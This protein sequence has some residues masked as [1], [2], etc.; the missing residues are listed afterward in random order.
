MA[1]TVALESGRH[2]AFWR[3]NGRWRADRIAHLSR[4]AKAWARRGAREADAA[5]GYIAGNRLV[6]AVSR[7]LRSAVTAYDEDELDAKAEAGARLCAALLV[8]ASD[9]KDRPAPAGTPE[10]IRA[11]VARRRAEWLDSA[12]RYATSRGLVLPAG[13]SVTAD[14]LRARL[15]DAGWWRRRLRALYGRAAESAFRDLG[16]VHRHADPYITDDGL[17]RYFEQ[18]A[19]TA[20]FLGS[21]DVACEQTGELFPLADIA[22]K[23]LACESIRRG[24]LA[25]R[26]RGLEEHAR[27][28]GHSWAFFTLTAPSAFHPRLAA[29]GAPNPAYQ[30]STVREARD[31]LQRLWSRVRAKSKRLGLKFYG[32]RVAEPHHDGTP[33]WHLMMFGPARDLAAL[34]ECIQGYWYS[35]HREEL[36]SPA[37]YEARAQRKLPDPAKGESATGYLL[38]YIA[39]GIDGHRLDGDDPE[40]T[41]LTGSE[42]SARVVAWARLHGIRQFQ[43]IGGPRV[44]IYRELRRLREPVA[45][46]ALEAAR[47]AADSGDFAAYWRASAGLALDK[48]APRTVDRHGRRVLRLTRWGEVPADR[49]IGVSVVGALGRIVRAVTRPFS[50][51]RIRRAERVP[52]LGPVAIT[53]RAERSEAPAAGQESAGLGVRARQLWDRMRPKE[54]LTGAAADRFDR[55]WAAQLTRVGYQ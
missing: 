8:G 26:S 15:S 45:E 27:A 11:E 40:E 29:S 14:G 52:D 17:R 41:D 12:C 10:E 51:V 54:P 30:R 36:T 32:I 38:K 31:H 47:L 33:H 44:G 50:W 7:E 39:K 49:A 43:Q 23:S 21:S 2:P 20:R 46:P 3:H 22:A 24:E 25:A 42:A 19:R 53:V 55:E 9:D 1:V 28:E 48:D 13:A 6:A 4:G 34:W 5:G 37:A 35:T 16:R 18:R